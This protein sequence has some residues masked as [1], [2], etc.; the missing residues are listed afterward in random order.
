MLTVVLPLVRR[1]TP[2]VLRAI[3][4][5]YT[6]ARGKPWRKGVGR[7]RV[8][9]TIEGLGD[10]TIALCKTPDGWVVEVQADP[11]IDCLK[12]I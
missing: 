11:L 2:Q 7:V 10:I 3:A 12:Q 5:R 1:I 4:S 9:V 6:A 8:T